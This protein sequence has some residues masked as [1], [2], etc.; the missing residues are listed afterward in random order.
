[1]NRPAFTLIEL[2]V[3]IILIA[4]LIGL[5]GPAGELLVQLPF[6]W[7]LFLRRV[8]P[9]L[10]PDPAVA[11][12][13][14]VCLAGFAVGLH[15][16]LRWFYAAVEP[17]RR[18]KARWTGSIVALVMVMFVAGIATVGIAHQTGWL[19]TTQPLF[20]RS[21][22]SR[23]ARRS[24]SINNLKQIGL[25]VLNY[26]QNSETFPPGATFDEHGRAL[27]GWQTALLPWIDQVEL[28]NQVNLSVPWND[29]RNRVPMQT[30]IW[31]YVNP[32]LEH[33]PAPVGVE[34]YGSSHYAGNARMLGVGA[35]SEI[36]D[37]AAS[38]VL[39]GGV[40]GRFRAWG[41]PLNWRD[42]ALGI[43]RS[44]SGFGGPSPEGAHFVFADGSVHFL[45][46]TIDPRVLNA[47]ST[48]DGGETLPHAPY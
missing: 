15:G 46:S 35:V 45:K 33:T 42:P 17:P 2:L 38:T 5:L 19:L 28:Y 8:V 29:P 26:V 24:A 48:P 21:V 32:E 11:A 25:G 10:R 27:H 31:R 6:G 1:M 30:L 39:A 12:T 23:A 43:N 13:G 18:W 4:I 22:A 9:L 7:V 14:A 47:L 3:V 34:G 44:Q 41:D 40:A 16:F 20:E 36:K 37:G